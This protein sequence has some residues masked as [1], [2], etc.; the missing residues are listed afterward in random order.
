MFSRIY[1]YFQ[2]KS[3]FLQKTRHLNILFF[4]KTHVPVKD[5]SYFSSGKEAKNLYWRE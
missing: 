2:K 3:N 4:L 5:K 1:I